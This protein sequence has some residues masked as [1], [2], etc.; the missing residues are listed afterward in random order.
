MYDER[1][2]EG[3]A[4]RE[5]AAWASLCGNRRNVNQLKLGSKIHQTPAAEASCKHL[6]SCFQRLQ[7]IQQPLNPRPSQEFVKR[8]KSASVGR[9]SHSGEEEQSPVGLWGQSPQKPETYAEY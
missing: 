6:L 7:L 9:K 3:L 8:G 1:L 5:K 2:I 4:Q